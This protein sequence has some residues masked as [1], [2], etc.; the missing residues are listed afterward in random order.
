MPTDEHCNTRKGASPSTGLTRIRCGQEERATLKLADYD[1][2]E[3][4]KL[5]RRKPKSN[6]IL[7]YIQQQLSSFSKGMTAGMSRIETFTNMEGS[8]EREDLRH[9][10][11]F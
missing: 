3:I 10:T 4:M 8:T 11:I 2:V 9:Q 5:G 7:E 1:V 6:I